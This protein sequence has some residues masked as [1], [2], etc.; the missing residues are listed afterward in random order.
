MKGLHIL[1]LCKDGLII[2]KLVFI[3]F[4]G[5]LYSNKSSKVTKTVLLQ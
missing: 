1:N 4:K 3:I 5:E 2:K